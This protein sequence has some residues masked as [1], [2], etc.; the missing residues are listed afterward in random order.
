MRSMVKHLSL[1]AGVALMAFLDAVLWIQILDFI[2][3]SDYMRRGSAR[4]WVATKIGLIALA[5]IPVVLWAVRSYF[6]ARREMS[7]PALFLARLPLVCLGGLL[8]TYFVVLQ[9]IRSLYA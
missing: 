6:L 1:W 8:L 3:Y 5:S 9:L 2:R 7:P 4:M